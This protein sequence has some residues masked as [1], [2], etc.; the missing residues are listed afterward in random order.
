MKVVA[1]IPARYESSRFQGKP[2]A[3]IAGKPMI[4]H[5]YQR[6]ALCKSVSQVIVAT[7][8]ERIRDCVKDFSGHVVMTGKGHH[9][10]TD[11]VAEAARIMNLRDQ[12]IVVNI[13]GDQ[14]LLHPESIS[15]LVTPLLEDPAIPM[16]TLIYKISEH[17]EVQDIRNVKAV[18][19]REGFALYFSR[20]PIPYFRD[21]GPGRVY[22]K[23]LGF[24]GY[25]MDFLQVFASLPPGD[26]EDKEK[27]EQLRTLEHG[28]KIKLIETPHDSVE[29]DSPRDIKEV[30][31]LLKGSKTCSCRGC[32]S[33]RPL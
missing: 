31:D 17:H 29:V 33:T 19:D 30:E 23:H 27:L 14:P 26:L 18:R 16:T 21:S 7:D 22:Y 13:Q 20:S 4:Q 3:P 6:A 2:L 24:Y 12:D 5:V 1:F 25:R 11:R 9:S 8:D 28:H 15:H 10:G 32:H